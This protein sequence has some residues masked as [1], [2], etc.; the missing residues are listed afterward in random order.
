MNASRSHSKH[1]HEGARGAESGRPF[2]TD[3]S[4]AA[5][6]QHSVAADRAGR[7]S[8]AASFATHV[9]IVVL[10]LAVLRSTA[11]LEPP[12]VG[13]RGRCGPSRLVE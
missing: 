4:R 3:F 8:F 5:F 10:A 13:R 11:P 12:A 2:E 7:V 1:H 9:A 6:V